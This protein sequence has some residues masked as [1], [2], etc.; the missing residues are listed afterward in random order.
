MPV[1][2]DQQTNLLYEVKD[3]RHHLAIDNPVNGGPNER[4][5][6]R[7]TPAICTYVYLAWICLKKWV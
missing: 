3:R 1:E 7:S 5:D 6:L 2:Y 4:D